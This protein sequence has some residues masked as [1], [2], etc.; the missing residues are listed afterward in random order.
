MKCKKACYNCEYGE[1]IKGCAATYFDPGEPDAYDCKNERVDEDLVFAIGD[2]YDWEDE[3]YEK[4]AEECG[5]YI[6]REIEK[7]KNCKKPMNE[8][9]Y[10]WGIWAED[11]WDGEVPVC[12]EKCKE[13]WKQKN[14][15]TM[16]SYDLLD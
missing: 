2:R 3:A 8:N 6:P 7:C 13:E 4:I 12:S 16:R 9:I 11:M 5:G 10:S 15:E 14:I 1:F